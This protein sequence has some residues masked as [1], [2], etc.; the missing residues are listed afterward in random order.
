MYQKKNKIHNE[1]NFMTIREHSNLLK[2]FQQGSYDAITFSAS[3]LSVLLSYVS[4]LEA[5]NCTV[6]WFGDRIG[7]QNLTLQVR[8]F[9]S[10][11]LT[12]THIHICWL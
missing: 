7:V 3:I 1:P 2:A 11:F 10:H 5:A 12:F 9:K 8:F 6:E 4:L